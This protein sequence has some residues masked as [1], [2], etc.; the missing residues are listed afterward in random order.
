MKVIFT[1]SNPPTK[2]FFLT[3]HNVG[4]LF[5]TEFLFKKYRSETH[6][7]KYYTQHTF[8][9]LPNTT[10]CLIET[11]MNLSGAAV[12]AFLKR[13]ATIK[14]VDLMIVHDDL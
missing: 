2:E 14:P 3:R 1:L 5:A 8:S 12:T 7:S 6:Q 10:V 13:N 11:Y 4:R 9:S